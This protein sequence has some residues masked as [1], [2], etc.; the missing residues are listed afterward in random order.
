MCVL[1]GDRP[2]HAVLA[3][4]SS[5][6]QVCILGIWIVSE[7]TG[8]VRTWNTILRYNPDLL[9]TDSWGR[10]PLH[11]AVAHSN[12]QLCASILEVARA[13]A[14]SA[15]ELLNAKCS[16]TLLYT[17]NDFS[18]DLWLQEG[19]HPCTTPVAQYQVLPM[20][21]LWTFCWLGLYLHALIWMQLD[22][23]VGAPF[24]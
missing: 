4:P 24:T 3:A 18:T 20:L 14:G 12:V 2:L 9:A 10:T 11:K 1:T 19:G 17:R 23:G 7:S 16:G 8:Q 22:Q 21:P 15:A 13:T 6:G 5:T